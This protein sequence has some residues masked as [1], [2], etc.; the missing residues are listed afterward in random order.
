MGEPN[1]PDNTSHPGETL[2]EM[3]KESEKRG[4]R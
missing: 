3:L 1:A 4:G 2:R